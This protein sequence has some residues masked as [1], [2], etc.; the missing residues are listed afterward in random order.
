MI[1]HFS[2]PPSPTF[3]DPQEFSFSSFFAS[4]STTV[5]PLWLE[6]E[7]PPTSSSKTPPPKDNDLTVPFYG[8]EPLPDDVFGGKLTDDFIQEHTRSVLQE[9]ETNILNWKIAKCLMVLCRITKNQLP[10][11]RPS[12]TKSNEWKEL[13]ETETLFQELETLCK[14][15]IIGL[16]KICISMQ[17][18]FELLCHAITE[19]GKSP[20]KIR[21]ETPLSSLMI[22]PQVF[23]RN[24][25]IFSPA[26]YTLGGAIQ[27]S[28]LKIKIPYHFIIFLQKRFPC[29][30][31]QATLIHILFKKTIRAFL[32]VDQ[33]RDLVS[34]GIGAFPESTPT[35][36]R[37]QY[38]FESA[39]KL[40][41]V[42]IY[43]QYRSGV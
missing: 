40:A 42:S 16:D 23:W 2:C 10:T 38:P 21:A 37:P 43:K 13:R 12:Y 17:L 29:P 8:A 35:K 36:I 19:N 34:K 39:L 18:K 28:S 4:H 33:A 26:E 14:I 5:P 7:S 31:S 1:P 11:H 27:W 6:A 15:H 25:P 32:G 3:A 22:P 20:F 24:T 41:F 9:R 30:K